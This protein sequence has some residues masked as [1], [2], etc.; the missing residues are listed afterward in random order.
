[1]QVEVQAEIPLKQESHI[2]GARRGMGC[3]RK[4]RLKGEA[5]K[6]D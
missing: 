4:P 3:T 5:G 2:E 1:M 6:M